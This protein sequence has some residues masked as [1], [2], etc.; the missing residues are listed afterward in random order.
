[1]GPAFLILCATPAALEPRRAPTPRRES[2][3]V[4]INLFRLFGA[5]WRPR[6]CHQGEQKS[7]ID[8][9]SHKT[10]FAWLRG[11]FLPG[12]GRAAR[13]PAREPR[14][15][16]PRVLTQTHHPFFIETQRIS[17]RPQV[18]RA[19]P[20]PRPPRIK[21]RQHQRG[22]LGCATKRTTLADFSDTIFMILGGRGVPRRGIWKK[23][24]TEKAKSAFASNRKVVRLREHLW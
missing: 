16:P 5:P 11:L 9:A 21:T 23:C 7:D 8:F 24:S 1:M 22:S 18:L 10:M 3:I 17:A 2:T 12:F 4:I 6:N 15:S 19:A 20:T 14:E 13:A